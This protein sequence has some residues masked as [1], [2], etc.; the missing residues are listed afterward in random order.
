MSETMV[1]NSLRAVRYR[2][3]HVITAGRSISLRRTEGRRRRSWINGRRRSAAA[4]RRHW[5]DSGGKRRTRRNRTWKNY[6]EKAF[7]RRVKY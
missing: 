3:E 5:K 6:S 7:Q 2:R 4:E 1:K